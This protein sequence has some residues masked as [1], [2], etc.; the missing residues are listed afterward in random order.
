MHLT[1]APARDV[2]V[3]VIQA[4]VDVSD[5]RWH[6]RKPF[7][8]IWQIIGIGWLRIDGDGFL[9]LE[10]AVIIAPPGEDRTLKVGG[11]YDNPAE[12]VLFDRVMGRADFQCH[13]VVFTQINRLDIGPVAQVPEMDAV[14]VFV[15]K[16][17]FGHY[18]VSN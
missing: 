10:C 17:V 5:Q 1:G 18:P 4:Q 14:T 11:V 16:Q 7:E 15:R 2:E 8:Q 6:R 9:G 13:L 12:P 3:F